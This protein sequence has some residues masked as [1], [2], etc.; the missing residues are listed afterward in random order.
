MATKIKTKAKVRADAKP[1]FAKILIANRGEIACRVMRT[2]RRLGIKT[3]AVYSEADAEALHVGAI[4]GVAD[5]G[6]VEEPIVHGS[7]ALGA[8]G[9]N[10]HREVAILREALDQGAAPTCQSAGDQ[11]EG[12]GERLQ[13]EARIVAEE[14]I[15]VGN[16]VLYGATEGECYFRG[17]AGERFAVRNSGAVA[18]V[19]GVGDHGCEYMT[20]GVVVVIGKVGRNFAAGMS[21]G[22][23]YVL[24]EAGD[25]AE[26]CNMAMVELEPV[27]EEDEL[28]E[29]L[30]HHGGDLEFK[31]RIDVMAN[32]SGFDAERLLQ[33]VSNHYNYTGSTRAKQ[34]IDNWAAYLPRFVKVMPVEYRRALQEIQQAQVQVAAE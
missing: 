25:F 5:D 13:L 1:P 23:A 7:G 12:D 24:D 32:M 19:E 26:R 3:V 20:G 34:I 17:V 4:Q 2:C 6:L 27:P 16:T 22:I 15:I 33:L 14:S 30:H 11:L 28:L 18:V 9:M 31:G 21:G 29:R 8:T 10:P